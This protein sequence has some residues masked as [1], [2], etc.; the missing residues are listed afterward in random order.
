MTLE[1]FEA[2]LAK[3]TS[4][5]EQHDCFPDEVK[6]KMA[7]I[8]DSLQK[9]SDS[10]MRVIAYG[11]FAPDEKIAIAVCELVLSH[12][13][14]LG[15]K[16]LK[17]LKLTMSPEVETLSLN[18]DATAINNTVEAY[19]V[20]TLGSFSVRLEHDADTLKIYGRSD[21]HLRFLMVLLAAIQKDQMAHLRPSKQGR[22]L[23]LEPPR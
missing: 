11:V 4:E 16:W 1:E 5:A 23:V 10:Q 19:R 18:G 2:T 21:E 6:Q 15:G 22:W 20:A 12:K 14:Q 9:K 13:G 17:L 8:W 7:W 3:W